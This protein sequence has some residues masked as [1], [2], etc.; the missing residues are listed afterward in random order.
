LLGNGTACLVWSSPLSIDATRPMR[1]IDLMGGQKPHL[2]AKCINNLGAETTVRYAPSTKFYLADRLAGKP[3][4]TRL[5][6]PVHVVEQVETIDRVSRN[7]FTSRYA[8][9]HGYFDGAEREFRG[10]GMVEQW[11]TEELASLMQNGTL[12]DPTNIDASS[13]V[14]PVHTKTWFHTGVFLNRGHISDFFAGLLK[15][16]GAGEYF[17][18]PGLTDDKARDRLLDDTVLP[19]G[20]TA[21]EE[22]E[23]CRAL[24]GSMLR[25]EV[26]ADDGTEAEGRPYSVT[27]QNFTLVML[28]PEAGQR[29]AVFLTH[30]RE[31]IDYHYERKLYPVNGTVIAAPGPGVPL[32]SDP[33]VTH[34]ITL[35]VDGFGNVLKSVSIGYGR[36]LSDP[37]LTLTADQGKQTTPLI[38]Y[39][40]NAFTNSLEGDDL[41]RAPLPCEAVTYELTGHQP[42]GPAG[43]FQ[44]SDFV[45]PDLDN[46][47][48]VIPV[49]ALELKYEDKPGAGLQRRPIAHTRTLFRPD[50]L[51]VSKGDPDSLLALGVVE[52]L[53]LPGE[54]YKL[55]FTPGLL[56]Q[57][58]VR[59]HKG[60]PDEP[61]LPAATRADVL[62]ADVPG[63]KIADRGGYVDLD[64]NGHW[65]I[66]SGRIFHSPTVGDTAAAE[67]AWSRLHFFLPQRYRD[68]F[69]QTASVTFDGYDLLT[70]ETRDALG[71]RI[72]AGERNAAGVV[73]KPGNDYRV[74]QPAL[75]ADANRNRSA[76]VFDALGMVAGTAVMGKPEENLGD[77]LDHFEPDLTQAQIDLFDQA[78]RPQIPAAPLLKDAT[79]RIV[80]DLG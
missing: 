56:T 69:G 45:Q 4:I 35:E 41:H 70:T 2:L 65:W 9:H 33:R 32:R 62:A 63:G 75:V 34:A 55:A 48:H 61:L 39:T 58:F 21:D 46:P 14:P 5:S 68:P 23:A 60:N 59:P 6:F 80:Y 3:W 49:A 19:G 74:L 13:Y 22:R 29:H 15:D 43:R 36:A 16:G 38:T 66:P 51:G 44:S 26:Y 18:E 17:R 67:L 53:A 52:P 1:Y 30:P 27:E 24:K 72:T 64:G 54:F 10:F 78:A 37:A 77:S 8:Y 40:E 25:H 12:P 79:T 76:V 20:L 28:Q 7:R 47:G 71:N 50:D 31:Q 42:T 57:V 73:T 11:D